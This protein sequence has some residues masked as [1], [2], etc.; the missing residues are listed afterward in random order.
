V[1]RDSARVSA[2]G[3]QQRDGRHSRNAGRYGVSG[4]I[5]LRPLKR[6]RGI[7]TAWPGVLVLAIIAGALLSRGRNRSPT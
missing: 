6:P 4:A 3:Q 7:R 1:I 2:V 5:I